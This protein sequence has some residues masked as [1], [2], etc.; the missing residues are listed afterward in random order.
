MDWLNLKAALLAEG[1]VKMVGVPAGAYLASSTAGP[2][3][4]GKGAVFFS[5]DGRR[6]RLAVD[7][8]ASL[9]LIHEGKGNAVIP[10]RGEMVRGVLEAPGLHCPRQAYITL[11][12]RCIFSCRYCA[13]PGSGGR[14]KTTAEVVA[15]VRSVLNRIDA[16]SITSGVAGS[17][18]EEERRALEVVRALAPFDLPIG[19]SIYP[20]RNTPRLLWEAGVAEVKF[21]IEAATPGIFAEM[22][23]GQDWNLLWEVLAAS[24][25]L[26][27]KN[28]VQSNIIVGLG[29]SDDEM[30]EAIRQLCRLGVIPILRPLTP[31]AGLSH[32]RRP[33]ASRLLRLHAVAAREMAAAGLDAVQ[34]RTM[35]AA[36]TGCDLI[37]G[38]D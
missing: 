19:V 38:R 33:D 35:C 10:F 16:V 24:V 17:V 22:C 30:E 21:N 12:E 9:T 25:R 14:T 34:A 3:A 13:V 1:R 37:P 2:G 26:F 8:E 7:P 29:E 5:V 31:A 18:E 6:I 15:L 4:G 11:S 28:H 36:C 23:P 20:T 32:Y 27:G